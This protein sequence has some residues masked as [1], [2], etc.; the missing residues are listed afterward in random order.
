MVQDCSN[1][2][3]GLGRDGTAS[4]I[5]N[6]RGHLLDLS[7][8][9]RLILPNRLKIVDL[10][11]LAH[12]LTL[13]TLWLVHH[14]DPL[15]PLGCNNGLDVKDTLELPACSL[16]LLTP[17][18]ASSDAQLHPHKHHQA[19]DGLAC[20]RVRDA[21]IATVPD[22]VLVHAVAI[23]GT[24]YRL[25]KAL[26]N[27]LFD[28]EFPDHDDSYPGTEAHQSTSALLLDTLT[29]RQHAIGHGTLR[30]GRR[31]IATTAHVINWLRRGNDFFKGRLSLALCFDYLGLLLDQLVSIVDIY[32]P[33]L[34]VLQTPLQE[35]IVSSADAT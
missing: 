32:L 7:E 3:L 30:H 4:D 27:W 26:H 31:S 25:L 29:E 34:L 20:A 28:A 10:I 5:A 6:E 1:L 12:R 17:A 16:P 18:H 11:V 13:N 9:G 24:T 22:H 14:I 15:L 19:V 35:V 8:L 23:D 33:G 2:L 21:R